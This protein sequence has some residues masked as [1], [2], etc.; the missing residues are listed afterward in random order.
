MKENIISERMPQADSF[1]LFYM[2]QYRGL[3][4]DMLCV[5]KMKELN[6]RKFLVNLMG[7]VMARAVFAGMNPIAIGYFAAVYLERK[8]RLTIMLT[9]LL[10][11]LTVLPAV[12][13][14]KYVIVIIVISIITALMEYNNKK[15]SVLVLGGLAGAVT[16][17]ITIAGG[18][19]Y[20]NPTYYIVTGIGEG[21]SIFACSFVFRKGLEPL[22]HGVRGQALDNEQIISIAVILAVFIY[23]VPEFTALGFSLSMT[24]ALFSILFTGYK[25]G[26]GYGALAGAACGVILALKTGQPNQ[27][28]LMC[29]LGIV[30]GTFREL[31]RFVT[32]AL[33]STG[34]IILGELYQNTQISMSGF[35]ALAS[36]A[37]LFLLLPKTLIYKV[38]PGDEGEKEDIFVKQSIQNVAKGKLRDFSES[39]HSLSNT[40]STIS[41]KRTAL[42]KKD[43][44][45]IFDEISEHLC[46]D[47]SNC[48][49]CWES[50]FYETYQ[51]AYHILD[52]VEQNGAIA[53]SEVPVE[54]ANRCIFLDNF[55]A[56][57][58]RVFE[59]AKLNLSW[60]NRMAESRE[61]IAG[62]L[63]EVANIIDDFSLDLYRTVETPEA[64]K[65]KL[66]Y[67]LKANHIVVKRIAVFEKRNN[68]REIYMTARTERGRC[69]TTKEAAGLISD[70]FDKRMRPSDG[71]KK[72]IT[73]EYETFIF[74]ED[75]NFSVYTGMSK[76]TK[77]GGRISGDNYSFIYPDPG[78]LVMT[79]SDGMG[80][81]ETA[82]EES[83]SVVELLEQFIEA[84]FRKESAIKLI[85]SILV[86][87]SE[88]QTFSTID[89][90]VI[91]LYTGICDI[92]KI[93][94]S[95]TFLKREERVEAVSSTTLP[96]GILNQVDYDVVTKK[97]ND[98]NFVIMITDGVIDCI[99]G[100]E[101]EKFMADFIKDLKM[102]NPQEIANAVLNQAL[103]L[104]GWVP[105]DDMTVLVA[106]FWSK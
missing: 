32:I 81:G 3:T 50:Y 9:V 68:K 14:A 17:A 48:N 88:E 8:G 30:A 13:T 104:N 64:S 61:A 36:C 1:D 6:M 45:E 63:S 42:S 38:N 20:E 56:E 80:T 47:C 60:I 97:L 59:M 105:K 7:I 22:M 23:G 93:G 4:P 16:A 66:I 53:I 27:I 95:T 90:S 79:L 39:F 24:I 75:A 46:K 58:K 100:D 91:N 106:G 89:M 15:V 25:Y 85:N 94:A 101:K 96:V 54:F 103:E 49:I 12:D 69:I 35:G 31:G 52:V 41:E 102:N 28:G 84:G 86:L 51:G 87:R 34:V 18:L 33:Y 74:V 72:V 11:M 71:C 98:G 99:P 77:E 67:H 83:E 5:C 70:V 40:F 73:K 76:M 37:V 82:C 65:N 78:T 43:K 29:M 26:A 92:I 21:I 2:W 62:Q 55:L 44:S 19:M 57:T 10:G